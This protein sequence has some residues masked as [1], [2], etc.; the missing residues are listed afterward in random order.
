MKTKLVAFVALT[1]TSGAVSAQSFKLAYA[2]INGIMSVMP[3]REK[4]NEDLQTYALGLQKMLEDVKAQRES[5]VEKYQAKSQA[6]DTTGLGAITNQAI[7]ADQ[8]FQ[9][10]NQQAEAKLA[11]KRADLMKPVVQRVEKAIEKIAKEGGYTYVLNSIDGSGT[12]NILYGPPTDNI[13]MKVVKEL[14]IKLE[15]MEEAAPANKK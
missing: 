6:K 7:M 1:L 13:T 10:A 5:A 4:I 8:N 9:K 2:D 14:G 15:G 12:S 3:E 11:E